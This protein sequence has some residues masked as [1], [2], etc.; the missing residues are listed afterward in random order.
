MLDERDRKA[1]RVDVEFGSF[2]DK[3]V[4]RGEVRPHD[5]TARWAMG[6]RVPDAIVHATLSSTILF[7]EVLVKALRDARCTGWSVYDV[8]LTGKH[9]EDVGTYFGLIVT[10]R[11]GPIEFGSQG[12]TFRK[13]PGGDIPYLVGFRFDEAS[14]DG[15]D[16]FMSTRY[17]GIFMTERAREAILSLAKSVTFTRL[18]EVEITDPSWS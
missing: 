18:T 3:A 17:G 12:R 2:N 11:C 9:G 15:S 14:W 16:I 5:V 7:S 1:F 10:G 6:K 8:A 13:M 4:R